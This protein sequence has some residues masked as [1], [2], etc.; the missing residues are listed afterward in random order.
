MGLC[1][2]SRERRT[3]SF[4]GVVAVGVDHGE[5]LARRVRLTANSRKRIL[6]HATPAPSS[7]M[8]AQPVKTGRGR[9]GVS[10]P[11]PSFSPQIPAA[12]AEGLP[13]VGC[14]PYHRRAAGH[15]PG[16]APSVCLELPPDGV[17]LQDARRHEPRGG[18]PSIPRLEPQHQRATAVRLLST[19]GRACRREPGGA[20]SKRFDPD[21]IGIQWVSMISRPGSG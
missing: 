21:R 7:P 3:R 1:K 9:S 17:A 15:L 8:L 11:R 13:I 18:R 19:R 6:A 14:R 12:V 4:L 10:R 16:V 20:R 5:H 2:V